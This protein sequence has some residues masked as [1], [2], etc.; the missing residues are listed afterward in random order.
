[1]S[2]DIRMHGA[3]PL[4]GIR[5]CFLLIEKGR[6]FV[7]VHPHIL[8]EQWLECSEGLLFDIIITRC[9]AGVARRQGQ[10]LSSTLTTAYYQRE[11]TL[12][13]KPNT[14]PPSNVGLG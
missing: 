8:R 7:N 12:V 6:V 5:D 13:E 10:Q 4:Q 1:M 11:R 3:G 2:L 14:S 9:A